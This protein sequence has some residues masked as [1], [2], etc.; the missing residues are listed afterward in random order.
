MFSPLVCVVHVTAYQFILMCKMADQP[1]HTQTVVVFSG[2]CS[3]H[4]QKP[5]T[6]TGF[7]YYIAVDI[8]T[9]FLYNYSITA[10]L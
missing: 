5:S 2:V 3:C 6:F 7:G 4:E 9:V 10:L 8:A 1:S